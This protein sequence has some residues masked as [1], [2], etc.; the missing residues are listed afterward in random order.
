[1]QV[2]IRSRWL[3][4]AA[5]GALAWAVQMAEAQAMAHFD[6]PAQPLA[7]SLRAVG[8][9]TSTNILFDPPLVA[10]LKAPAVNAD[11]TTDQA[12]SHLLSGTGIR[13]RF[14]NDTTVVLDTSAATEEGPGPP[15]AAPQAQEW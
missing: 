13:Y 3:K 7:D 2:E 5:S 1:M 11:L 15:P 10:G 9:Q 12:I 14:L 6:I 8:S 4:A